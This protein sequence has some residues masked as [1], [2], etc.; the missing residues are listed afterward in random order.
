MRTLQTSPDHVVFGRGAEAETAR[1][2]A[3]HGAKRVLLVA[4]AHHRAGADRLAEALGDKAVGVFTTE[5]PQVPGEVADAAIAMARETGADWLCAHGG[6]TPIG[7]AKVVAREL[8]LPIAAV[9]TTYA[10]SERTNIWGETRD[11]IKTTGRDDKVRPRLVV[12]D[13]DLSAN[14]PPDLSYKSLFNALAHSLEALYAVE[15]SEHARRCAEESLEPLVA[16]IRGIH[17]GEDDAREQ[18]TYGAYL[19]SEALAGASMALHHKLAHVLGGSY[20]TSHADTHSILLSYTFGFNA[21][22]ARD[23]LRA[24]QDAWNT[25]DPPGFLYDLQRELGLKTSLRELGLDESHLDGIVEQVLAKRYDNPRDYD[26]TSLRSFLLDALHDRRPSLS[27]RRMAMPE[28]AVGPHA[29][30]E[31][32]ERG[33]PLREAKAVVLGVHGRGASADRFL[34]DLERRL[35]PRPDVCFLGAQARDNTWYP[36]GFRAPVEDNQ[37]KLDSTL[38]VVEALYRH[39]RAVVG[40]ERIVPV[41][42]SQGACTVLTWLSVTESRPVRVLAFTG[43][44]TELDGASFAAARGVDVHMGSA[45][46]DPWIDRAVFESAAARFRE[47]GAKVSAHLAPGEQHA[48]HDF[49]DLALRTAVAEAVAGDRL[50]YQR[51]FMGAMASEA[52]PNV[53]PAVQN[54]PRRVAYGLVAE[55]INGTG[56]TLERGLNQRTWMYRL[57]PALLSTPFTRYADAP[58]HFVGTFEH[59]VSSPQIRRFRPHPIPEKPTDFLHGLT[60]YAGAG[61]PS[62]R[63]GAAIHVYAANA[64]MT[65]TAM[66]N[67]DGD[68][69]L[70]PELGRLHVRTEL[71]RL[72]VSPGEICVIPRGIRF[73]VSLPDGEARG[74]VAEVFD[75]HLQLPNR[76]PVGANGLADER[77]F[78]SPVADFA[79]VEEPWTVLVRQGGV[80][81]KNTAS[82]DP[83]DVVAWHGNYAP[84][85]YDLMHFNSLGSVSWDHPD[86]SIL[87]VL[88]CPMDTHGRNALDI[89]VF[90]G[91][92]D[93]SEHSF[94]PPYFHRN[95]A[96]EF[97]GVIKNVEGSRTWQPGVFSWTPYL[98][99]HGISAHAYEREVYDESTEPARLPD[100]SLWIQF[101]STY[102][103]KVMKWWLHHETV[104]EDYLADFADYGPKATL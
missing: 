59:G 85:K 77:H 91:R 97:N 79:D 33:A 30:L 7:I 60:T 64:D 25:F 81:W 72:Q 78:L 35:G 10:G 96:V 36:K 39:A 26:A 103:L 47:A 46:G 54:S 50:A 93:A 21:P 66:C 37:P 29:E 88:T 87:T 11:G 23:A 51:G 49:D 83:F 68:L 42:F 92:W 13:P 34:A 55:Q 38:S 28:G 14:L 74:W 56:F 84:Y 45:A 76:G 65:R 40:D 86:P 67:I 98:S 17:R 94:R 18:A 41:G 71:G 70:V 32:T 62:E 9:P 12:Y 48:I 61:D 43:A 8:S 4:Q 15:V 2:L 69:C 89:A 22:A 5:V 27:T 104:E 82:H 57:R 16:G 24:A 44:H 90:R 73:T 101:E 53:L 63:R 1:L 6:G 100:E 102:P 95:S 31:I 80:L 99:P 19:A 75:A 52:R 58:S 20:G 3:E